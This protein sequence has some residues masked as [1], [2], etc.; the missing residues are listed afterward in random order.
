MEILKLGVSG[1]TKVRCDWGI[2]KLGV[3][4]NTKVRCEREY[5]S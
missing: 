1:N 4:G 3:T 5:Y 2:L